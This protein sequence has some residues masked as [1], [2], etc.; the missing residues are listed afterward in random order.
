MLVR[1]LY[2]SVVRALGWLSTVAR[3]DSALVTEVMVLRHEVAV[4]RRQVGRPAG[5]EYVVRPGQC[6]RRSQSDVASGG[7]GPGSTVAREP[8]MMACCV[9]ST[10]LPWRDLRVG[11]ATAAAYE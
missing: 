5:A 6:A 2:T 3:G 10:G 11:D 8:A 4:L 7:R 9:S 1:M